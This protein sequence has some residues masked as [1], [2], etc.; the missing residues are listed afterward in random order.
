MKKIYR[1]WRLFRA[2]ENPPSSLPFSAPSLKKLFS[3]IRPGLSNKRFRFWFAALSKSNLIRYEVHIPPSFTIEGT[4]AEEDK[5]VSTDPISSLF[6]ITRK[7]NAVASSLFIWHSLTTP[8]LKLL[9]KLLK[10]ESTAGFP[11]SSVSYI[12]MQN[13]IC[14]C[15]T[16]PSISHSEGEAETVKERNR[17]ANKLKLFIIE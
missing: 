4:Y 17:N 7:H 15:T 5:Q 14:Q 13:A 6:A 8:C 12:D 11:G 9:S 16:S 2:G 1:N 10:H 3:I